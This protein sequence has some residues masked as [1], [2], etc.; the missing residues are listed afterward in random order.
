MSSATGPDIYSGLQR[1]VTMKRPRL[2]NLERARPAEN[3]YRLLVHGPG[4]HFALPAARYREKKINGH[5]RIATMTGDILPAQKPSTN[6]QPSAWAHGCP[7][8]V[9]RKHCGDLERAHTHSRANC[10]GATGM[11]NL[12][13]LGGRRSWS[14]YEIPPQIPPKGTAAPTGD[15]VRHL[16]RSWPVWWSSARHL[17]AEQPAKQDMARPRSTGHR[18]TI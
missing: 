12:S 7:Q 17:A 2:G 1:A 4:P 6:R 3:L 10:T 14:S 11:R 13:G 16:A 8:G 5:P 15:L 18:P 9:G